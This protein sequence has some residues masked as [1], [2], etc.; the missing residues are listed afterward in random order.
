MKK[1]IKNLTEK[2]YDLLNEARSNGLRYRLGGSPKKGTFSV[3]LG[4]K[5]EIKRFDINNDVYIDINE[6]FADATNEADVARLKIYLKRLYICEIDDFS[7]AKTA[8]NAIYAAYKRA[9]RAYIQD[10]PKLKDDVFKSV[11][12]AYRGG[13]TLQPRAYRGEIYVADINSAYPYIVASQA[14]PY[15]NAEVVNGYA[16]K[17]G[18]YQR[19]FEIDYLKLSGKT[20]EILETPAEIERFF[21]EEPL[22]LAEQD[23]IIL[24]KI[25]Q[26]LEFVCKKTIFFKISDLNILKNFVNKTYVLRNVDFLKKYAKK[27]INGFI[28]F[29]GA[30]S[31][32]TTS[33][34]N[35]KI[36][37]TKE[38]VN[39]GYIA[40]PATINALQRLRIF[41]LYDFYKNYIVYGDTDSIF[42]TKNVLDAAL[43]DEKELGKFK[44][45]RYDDV[46]FFGKR[47]YILRDG[48]K[49]EP[50]VAGVPKAVFSKEICKKIFN[51][52]RVVLKWTE[53]VF[54]ENLKIKTE[55]RCLELGV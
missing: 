16:K 43:I 4:S 48:D 52:E 23:L 39:R 8:I 10:F 41:K 37:K 1:Y 5:N 53:R 46:V 2:S 54:D 47:A 25:Y 35:S 44:I 19:F 51:N 14:L 15:G 22:V 7:P 50:H 31:R 13:L 45:K 9:K 20:L 49:F 27:M 6:A 12:R 26:N 40:L 17:G 55:E 34:K 11:K 42:L 21:D 38:N 30:T 33:I 36:E 18:N 28:G 3:F 32:S 24:K 29:F